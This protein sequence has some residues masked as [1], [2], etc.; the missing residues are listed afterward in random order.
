MNRPAWKP[1]LGRTSR[2]LNPSPP[3]S[4]RPARED[5]DAAHVELGSKPVLRQVRVCPAWKCPGRACVPSHP[6]TSIAYPVPPGAPFGPPGHAVPAL[7]SRHPNPCSASAFEWIAE[8]CPA[9]TSLNVQ[10]RVYVMGGS[11]QDDT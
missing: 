10:V 8:G 11:G 2:R 1:L 9:L 5:D 6:G 3:L 7:T 4:D